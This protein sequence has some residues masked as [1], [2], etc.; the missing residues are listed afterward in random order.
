MKHTTPRV[1]IDDIEIPVKEAVNYLCR[2]DSI[3]DEAFQFMETV[4]YH[5]YKTSRE[6][7]R[8]L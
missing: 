8:E 5:M 7:R 6:L 1:E 4:T 2:E 3:Y